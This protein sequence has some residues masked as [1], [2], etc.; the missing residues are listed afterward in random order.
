MHRPTPS[1]LPATAAALLGLLWMF[2]AAVTAD[3]FPTWIGVYGDEV[4]HTD[5]QNPGTYTILLNED[6]FGLNASVGI[7]VN[8][9]A[10][11]EIPMAYAGKTNQDSRWRY[12]PDAAYPAG[13]MVRYYFH[14]WDGSGHIYDNNGG[15]DYA[16]TAAVVSVFAPLVQGVS[17]VV[18]PGLPGPLFAEA[19]PWVPIVGGDEDSSWPSACVYARTNGLG[20][21]VV[22]GA[23]GIFGAGELLDNARFLQNVVAWLDGAGSK[24]VRYTTGHG[25]WIQTFNDL[26]LRMAS[27]GYVFTALPDTISASQLAT[28]S[29]LIVGNAWQAFTSN[30]VD[31]VRQFVE[32]G[33]GLCLLG[34]GWSWEPYHPGSTIEQY[35]MMALAAPFGIRW[36]RAGFSDPTDLFN[37]WPRF[38]TFYPDVPACTITGAMD[39]LLQLHAQHTTNLPAVIQTNTAEGLAFTRAHQTLMVPASDRSSLRSVRGCCRNTLPSTD[40]W[41]STPRKPVPSRPGRVNGTGGRGATSSP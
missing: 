8:G 11:E 25:E 4:R 6:Y 33:G 23:D 1:R 35:P 32:N 39:A 29:V 21:V 9:G 38:H 31:A 26:A 12:T 41:R 2:V 40:A 5:N 24:A 27:N 17:Q 18:A 34:L 10:W 15:A 3:A 19:E 14:G 36:L 22:F 28:S 16:F 13:A 7:Q 20:R 37:G 30:E